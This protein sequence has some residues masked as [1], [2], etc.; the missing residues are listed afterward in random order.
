MAPKEPAKSIAPK[1]RSAEDADAFFAA[2]TFLQT[3][4]AGIFLPEFERLDM[5]VESI[6][7]CRL[8]DDSHAL[9]WT[10]PV[11]QWLAED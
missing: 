3:S 7:G 4:A 11:G 5:G 6:R 1:G 9:A 10:S 2:E 8:A